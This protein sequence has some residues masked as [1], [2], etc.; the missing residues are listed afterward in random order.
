MFSLTSRKLMGFVKLRL[1]VKGYWAHIMIME[2]KNPNYPF[3]SGLLEGFIKSL[4]WNRFVPG[5]KIEDE[6]AFSKWL[7]EQLKRIHEQSK[8]YPY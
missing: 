6:K 3:K 7:E 5:M 8:E 1:A 4:A 2:D